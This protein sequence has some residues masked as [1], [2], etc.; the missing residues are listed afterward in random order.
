MYL[1]IKGESKM[2]YKLKVDTINAILSYLAK[3]PL[4]E[5]LQ[6]FNQIHTEVQSQTNVQKLEEKKGE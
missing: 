2:E 1:L 5:V 4:E 6:L 3:K